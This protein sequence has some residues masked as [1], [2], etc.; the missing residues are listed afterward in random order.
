ML[1]NM[2]KY[3]PLDICVCNSII[4]QNLQNAST[5]IVKGNGGC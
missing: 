3:V 2:A 1:S 5:I 4:E